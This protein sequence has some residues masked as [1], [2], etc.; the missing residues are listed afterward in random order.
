MLI[1]MDSCRINPEE[2]IKEPARD[3]R[4]AEIAVDDEDGQNADDEVVA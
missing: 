2:W 1:L 3:G 4:I